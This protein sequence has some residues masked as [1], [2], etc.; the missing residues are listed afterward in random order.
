M[1]KLL[2]VFT[3]FFFSTTYC[4]D[5]CRAIIDWKFLDVVDIYDKPDGKLIHQMKNDSANEDYLHLIILKQTESYFFV[6]IVT[7]IKKEER[8]GWIKKASYIGAYK[9]HEKFPMDLTLYKDEKE[10]DKDKIV[11]TNWRPTLLTIEKCGDK[12]SLVSLK[13]NGHTF[14]GWIQAD[15]LCVNSYTYCN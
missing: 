13:Q 11:I 4:Q 6:S 15:E 5:K 9:K 14:K 8:K 12:W 1:K 3:L 2:A 7:E 10:S